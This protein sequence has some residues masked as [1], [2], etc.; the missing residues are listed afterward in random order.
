MATIAEITASL[1]NDTKTRLDAVASGLLKVYNNLLR[2]RYFQHPAWIQLGPHNID[3]LIPL[4][5]FLGID[6]CIIYLY[7]VLPYIKAPSE[8]TGFFQGSYFSDYRDEDDVRQGR[9]PFYYANGNEGKWLRGWQTALSTLGNHGTCLV[10]DARED[11]IG[12]FDQESGGSTDPNI[13]QRWA[14]SDDEDEEGERKEEGGEG[15]GGKESGGC[16]QGEGENPKVE[17]EDEEGD[18]KGDED[19]NGEDDNDEEEDEEEEE[20]EEEYPGEP[21]AFDEFDGRRTAKV[22]RDMIRWYNDFTEIPGCGECT[23]EALWDRTIVVPLYR[24]HGW[25]GKDFDGDAFQVDQRRAVVAMEIEE[26]IAGSRGDIEMCQDTLGSLKTRGLE[27]ARKKLEDAETLEKQWTA[28]WEVFLVEGTIE[29]KEEELRELERIHEGATSATRHELIFREIRKLDEEFW[30]QRRRLRKIEQNLKEPDVDEER[31][32]EL[33]VELEIGQKGVLFA[34]RALEGA[35]LDAE[36]WFPGQNPLPDDGETMKESALDLTKQLGN[37]IQRIEVCK[38]RSER[39]EEFMKTVPV[40]AEET[41]KTLQQKLDQNVS[42][43][44]ILLSQKE[45]VEAATAS[46]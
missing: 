20:E 29:E 13:D 35:R 27:E 41:K 30:D 43:L 18:E 37:L 22:L 8:Y 36:R 9:D 46:V 5:R 4:Y 42:A 16:E 3:H 32:V 1:D 31:R 24:K 12:M 10:Y 11:I 38:A 45:G 6:N 26:K 34:E 19:D 28:R 14:E 23:D 21:R 39:W 7:S 25:P 2:M 40:E 44:E 17:G 33:Q 15:N